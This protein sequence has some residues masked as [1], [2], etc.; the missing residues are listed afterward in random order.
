MY[1]SFSNFFKYLIFSPFDVFNVS[2]MY[3]FLSVRNFFLFFHSGIQ[4]L[5]RE[6]ITTSARIL[7]IIR[8]H[9][10]TFAFKLPQIF[11][12]FPFDVLN[13]SIFVN[14][15]QYSLPT[16]IYVSPSLFSFTRSSSSRIIIENLFNRSN[17]RVHN[18]LILVSRTK[19]TRLETSAQPQIS[20]WY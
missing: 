12:L 1:N 8:H 7:L 20:S 15:M 6:L 16:R 19:R 17:S 18:Y 2:R 14:I 5:C 10:W 4:S 3:I 11:N 9:H 13:F